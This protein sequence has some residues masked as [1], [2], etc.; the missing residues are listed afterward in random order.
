MLNL[1]KSGYALFT[2]DKQNIIHKKIKQFKD[3]SA[4]FHFNNQYQDP[5]LTLLANLIKC[6]SY[7]FPDIL[8]KVENANYTRTE[9]E[10]NFVFSTVHKSKDREWRNVI[11]EDDFLILRN[12]T[13]TATIV[14]Q[15][16]EEINLIYVGITRVINNLHMRAG[17]HGFIRKL[18]GD[19]ESRQEKQDTNTDNIHSSMIGNGFAIA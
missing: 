13:N 18:A 3:W 19:T 4:M 14:N 10:A 12:N 1:A 2:G 9:S 16:Q 8:K 15:A 5:E 11:V 6:Y 7:S 17:V